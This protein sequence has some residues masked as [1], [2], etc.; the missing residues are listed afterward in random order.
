MTLEKYKKA[1][2]THDWYYAWAD[3]YTEYSKG[4]DQR[5]ALHTMAQRHDPEF[6]LWNEVA[7]PQFQIHPK[8]K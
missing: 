6:T 7:P 3:G 2:Q 8:T 1:L 5:D 4:K